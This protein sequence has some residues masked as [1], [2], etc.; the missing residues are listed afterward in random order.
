MLG[1]ATVAPA[2][3]IQAPVLAPLAGQDRNNQ[4]TE[5]L[6]AS[7]DEP[8]SAFCGKG[9]IS[10]DPVGV[11]STACG[12]LDGFASFFPGTKAALQGTDVGEA[13]LAQGVGC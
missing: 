2:G 10:H 8:V 4:T 3:P 5:S 11:C 1:I 9:F 7:V 13:H 6:P 12:G